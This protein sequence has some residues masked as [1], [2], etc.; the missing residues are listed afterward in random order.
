[1]TDRPDYK[2]EFSL[3]NYDRE[4]SPEVTFTGDPDALRELFAAIAAARGEFLPIAKDIEGQFQNRKFKYSD[5]DALTKASMSAL[6]KYKVAVMQ[7]PF[8]DRVTTVVAGCGATIKWTLETGEPSDMKDMGARQTYARRYSY[9]GAFVLAGD[10]DLDQQA[11]N[12]AP[13]QKRSAPQAP[14]PREAPQR[15]EPKRPAAPSIATSAPKSERIEAA[16]EIIQSAE[17]GQVI[18]EAIAEVRDTEPP[19]AVTIDPETGEVLD[20]APDGPRTK[21]TSALL[22]K[23]FSHV[24]IGAKSVDTLCRVAVGKPVEEVTRAGTENEAQRLIGCLLELCEQNRLPD[25]DKGPFGREQADT[26]RKAVE[27]RLAP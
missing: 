5:L 25:P 3:A 16:R 14:P 27:K 19:A 23:L 2:R 21:E 9:Q 26:L 13:M 10:E 6:S 18:K 1:M 15:P 17:T 7:F 22:T 11:N 4:F 20:E 8:R 12:S 24:R